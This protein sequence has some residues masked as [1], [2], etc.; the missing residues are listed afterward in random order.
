M[1]LKSIEVLH[2]FV[3]KMHIRD[4]KTA[5]FKSA[6]SFAVVNVLFKS[7]LSFAMVNVLFKSALSFA[8]V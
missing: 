4:K 6:L 5:S 8:V 7:A 1:V 2:F 3:P